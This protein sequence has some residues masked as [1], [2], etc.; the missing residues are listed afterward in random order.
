MPRLFWAFLCYRY[1]MGARKPRSAYKF[2][3]MLPLILKAVRVSGHNCPLALLYSPDR[4]R[5]W[6]RAREIMVTV[7]N[8]SL[9]CFNLICSVGGL[10]H[11][12]WVE[13]GRQRQSITGRGLEGRNADQ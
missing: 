6:A 13:Q 12:E 9:F 5:L 8:L 2:E 10:R 7:D 1:C 4:A 3:L 11:D